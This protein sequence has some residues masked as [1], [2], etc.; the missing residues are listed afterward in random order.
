MIAPMVEHFIAAGV[1]GLYL[2]GSTGSGI[3]MNVRDWPCCLSP[4]HVLPS[5]IQHA[6]APGWWPVLSA[7]VKLAHSA[8][9]R[10]NATV[11][12]RVRVCVLVRACDCGTSAN[13]G[14]WSPLQPWEC[15][16]ICCVFVAHCVSYGACPR[17]C[18]RVCVRVR[19][20]V[21]VLHQ[22]FL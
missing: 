3:A 12:W 7:P 9:A 13:H 11:C 6:S 20:R 19:V 21:R 15:V 5:F 16:C 1:N 17:A 14:E 8:V 4:L 2:C 18:V 22:H 10:P